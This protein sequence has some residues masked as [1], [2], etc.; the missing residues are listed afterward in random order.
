LT[1]CYFKLGKT[2]RALELQETL[3]AT[4]RTAKLPPDELGV[5]IYNQACLYAMNGWPEKAL[6]L[7]PEALRLRP[8]LI[9]WSKHDSDLDALRADPSFQAIFQDAAL[10]EN[11]PTSDLISPQEAYASR[12]AEILPMIIDVRGPGE[13]ASG[14]VQGASNITLNQLARKLKQFPRDRLLITYCNMHHRGESRGERGAALLR[15]QGFQARTID[16]G[17]PAWKDSGLPVEAAVKE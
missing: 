5:I 4:A 7:L 3:L 11:A 8:T 6:A 1:A 13:F 16:G 10:M 2:Q 12:N 15:E 9:E 17:Y 14:H